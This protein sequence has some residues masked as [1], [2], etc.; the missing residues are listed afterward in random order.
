MRL[1]LVQN[2][3]YVPTLGGANKASRVLLEGLSRL[4]YTCRVLA[5]THGAHGNRG[6]SE[7]YAALGERG[8][9]VQ[10]ATD[11]LVAFEHR[12]VEVRAVTDASH[13]RRHLLDQIQTFEPAWTLIPS[14]DPGQVLLQAA[15]EAA[16]DRVIYL[17]YTTMN[18]PFGPESFLPSARQTELVRRA[19]GVITSSRHL[20]RYLE[21]WAGVAAEVLGFPVYGDGPFPELG[22]PDQGAVTLINPC[23]VKGIRIFLALA[24]QMPE[25]EFAAVPTWGTTSADRAALQALPNVT[26]W[27]AED[28]L[29]GILART[30]VLLVPSLWDEAFGFVAVEGMLHG[31]P[32]LASQVGGLPEAK[33][34]IDHVLPVRPIERYL[35]TFDSQWVPVPVVPEQDVGPWIAALRRLLQDRDHYLQLSAASRRAAT[36]YVTGLGVAPFASYLARR[37]S[38]APRRGAA[39]HA[40]GEG[41]TRSSA[42]TLPELSPDRRALLARRVARA[43]GPR[44]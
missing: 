4:G 9:A 22:R 40:D 30:R 43:K 29:R 12:G 27:P 15:C 6:L 16:A 24:R 44:R 14:E 7:L 10:R 1:L 18:L 11:E 37:A 28:D 42:P 39:P 26:L 21:R 25:V 23:A 41:A 36:A 35:S 2:S 32:V 38:P 33:L 31:V 19:A 3:L 5:L 17:A 13:L 34:G 20:Q 8:I